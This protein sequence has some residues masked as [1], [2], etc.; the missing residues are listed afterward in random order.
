MTIITVSQTDCTGQDMPGLSL[1]IERGQQEERRPLVGPAG[2][3][4]PKNWVDQVAVITVGLDCQGEVLAAVP[5]LPH[6]PL[7]A[8][9]FGEVMPQSELLTRAAWHILESQEKTPL[10]DE[11]ATAI[12]A[13]VCL[14]DTD[15]VC[16]QLDVPADWFHTI[17]AL[18]LKGALPQDKGRLFLAALAR[19]YYWREDE[20]FRDLAHEFC[21]VLQQRGA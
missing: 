15:Q 12:E 13:G 19:A 18:F 9:L 1:V 5:H 11:Q 14:L 4:D 16:E 2:S 8:G 6:G 17:L 21:N 20:P 10:F 3:G 7:A